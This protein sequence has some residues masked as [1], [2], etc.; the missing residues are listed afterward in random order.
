MIS[1]KFKKCQRLVHSII[2]TFYENLSAKFA[3]ESFD[4]VKL[5]I[6]NK[7]IQ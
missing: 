2:G 6:D 7:N 5:I 3:R 4:L 1:E